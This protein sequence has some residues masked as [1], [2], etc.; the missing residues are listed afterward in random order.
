MELDLSNNRIDD[1]GAVALAEALCKN[2]SLKELCLDGNDGLGEKGTHQLMQAL[3]T[4][5]SMCG[6]GLRLPMRCECYPTQCTQYHSL[7]DRITFTDQAVHNIDYAVKFQ[8]YHDNMETVTR[9]NYQLQ[10]ENFVL[11]QWTMG[12]LTTANNYCARKVALLSE[13]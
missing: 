8:G 4:N 9:N 3:T 12:A 2:S 1:T 5:S 10:S 7:K 6:G 11:R 13:W